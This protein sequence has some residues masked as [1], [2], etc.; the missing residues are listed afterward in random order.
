M[1]TKPFGRSKCETFYRS[2][3]NNMWKSLWV[4]HVK[5]PTVTFHKWETIVNT[6]ARITYYTRKLG[7][8]DTLWTQ[9]R[10]V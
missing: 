10:R 5:M 1:N 4:E 8:W 9:V 6:Y 2:V 7:N 3:G